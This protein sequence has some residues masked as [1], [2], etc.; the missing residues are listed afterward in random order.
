MVE[1]P[2][3]TYLATLVLIL[4]LAMVSW[5]LSWGVNK[6]LR[7]SLDPMIAQAL[8]RSLRIELV[9]LSLVGIGAG[10]LWDIESLLISLIFGCEE[11]YETSLVIALLK[12]S[13]HDSPQQA[14][15]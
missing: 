4:G 9:G 10:W 13:T 2:W 1:I 7:E 12:R 8:V 11:L 3:N 15:A 5:G 6:V 14:Q